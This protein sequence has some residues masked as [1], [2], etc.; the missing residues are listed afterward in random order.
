MFLGPVGRD[1]EKLVDFPVR[2]FVVGLIVHLVGELV[3]FGSGNIHHLLVKLEVKLLPVILHLRIL[4]T[5]KQ[6]LNSINYLHNVLSFIV[7]T[8]QL[9]IFTSQ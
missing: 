8:L 4:F 9:Y 3:V 6:A 1:D 5:F 7:T 2:K